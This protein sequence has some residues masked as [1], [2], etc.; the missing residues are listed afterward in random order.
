M[1][2]TPQHT[3]K[4]VTTDIPKT[5]AAAADK[6]YAVREARLAADKVIAELKAVESALR[7]H[8]INELPLS[9]ALGVTGKL[10]NAT[11][12]SRPVA[13]IRDHAKFQ[14]WAKRKGNEDCLKIKIDCDL[15]AIRLRWEQ[16]KQ[17]PGVE[18]VNVK[19]VSLTKPRAR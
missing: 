10:V 14:A 17:V 19:N 1:S 18:R 15:E 3:I 16:G 2:S 6:L 13:S 9:D 4:S 5:L 12:T 8:L 7:E 11:I